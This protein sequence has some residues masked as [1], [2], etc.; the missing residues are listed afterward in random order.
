M[1]PNSIFESKS[2]ALSFIAIFAIYSLIYLKKSI[3]ENSYTSSS[4]LETELRSE[5][6]KL[7][8]KQDSL[9]NVIVQLKSELTQK[10]KNENKDD[11]FFEKPIQ[12][13][14]SETEQPDNP[15]GY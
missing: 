8:K 11:D 10:I 9:K 6:E 4:D 7:V 5:N 3:E 2:V 13:S 15:D 1:K 12:S 14:S